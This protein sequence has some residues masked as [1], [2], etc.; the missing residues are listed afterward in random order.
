MVFARLLFES[1]IE[2]GKGDQLFEEKLMVLKSRSPT[3]VLAKLAALT[4][5]Y[6]HTYRNAE[7]HRVQVQFREILEIQEILDQQMKDGTEV[8]F[9]FWHDPTAQDLQFL[10]HTHEPPWWLSGAPHG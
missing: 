8:F 2:E 1:V 10:R 6:E 7:G 9:R 4:K 3:K 5:S